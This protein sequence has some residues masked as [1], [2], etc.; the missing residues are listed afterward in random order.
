MEMDLTE[1]LGKCSISSNSIVRVAVQQT[2]NLRL[3]SWWQLKLVV[4]ESD[5]PHG[6][7]WDAIVRTCLLPGS[8]VCP[9]GLVP[10]MSF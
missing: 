2:K 9:R 4:V 3:T 8:L 7:A 5:L 1:R 10:L 6:T